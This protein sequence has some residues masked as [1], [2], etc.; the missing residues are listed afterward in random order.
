M[1]RSRVGAQV[2][3]KVGDGEQ[4][5]SET[6]MG[7]L[8]SQFEVMLDIGDFFSSS[9]DVHA[10]IETAPDPA[11]L[12]PVRGLIRSRIGDYA[13]A[14]ADFSNVEDDASLSQPL[15][16][17]L[18][19]AMVATGSH[20]R[21]LEV[22][23]R[24]LSDEFTS[25]E[26][27][28]AASIAAENSGD[29]ATAASY[30]KQAF[31]SDRDDLS[32][33]L[34]ALKLLS[35]TGDEDEIEDWRREVIG[36][37]GGS[38][39]GAFEI[40]VWAIEN[41]DEAMFAAGLRSVAARDKGGTVDLVED[42]LAAGMFD[43]VGQSVPLLV[44]IGR[45]P[46]SLAERRSAL[47]ERLLDEARQMVVDGSNDLAFRIARALVELDGA[48]NSQIAGRRL[49]GQA[50]RVLR[51][52]LV[53]VRS[54]VREAYRDHDFAGVCKIYDS[55]ADIIT[56]DPDVATIVARSLQA[57]ERE[58]EA[59]ALILRVQARSPESFAPTRW[60]ARLAALARNY[61]V[62]LRMYGLLRSD[63]PEQSQPIA[64]EVERF[65]A[66]AERVAV[67]QLRELIA[68]ERFEDASELAN[69]ILLE[70]NQADRVERELGR[71][72]RA[73]R[74]KLRG[75]DEGDGEIDEREAVLRQ[76]VTL[77]PEDETLLRRLALELMRQF[78]FL[79]AAE[80]W[81]RIVRIN[82]ENESAERNLERC[83]RLAAS[84][85]PAVPAEAD[86]SG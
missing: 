46:R 34:H 24:L 33:A 58:A 9:R 27:Y 68:E 55:Q 74:I 52:V 42:A 35:R 76:L 11:A 73:L 78:R 21:A 65:F 51:D 81:D 44:T 31:R 30:A 29:G 3:A 7:A 23:E 50:R 47:L 53:D 56:E 28:R 12:L 17:A 60:A 6:Q 75:I 4:P 10:A 37:A 20:E 80:I 38:S 54:S 57:A 14:V 18:L 48:S 59:L 66:I 36:N 13:G 45:V 32:A 79:E 77:K 86:G 16:L 62:A 40:C 19:K 22:A 15:R 61:T 64:S 71:M 1:H 2:L 49:A 63:F 8:A 67:R 70:L 5:D 43:A 25:A 85:A 69:I 84:R 26:I 41:R 72:V 82:P 83:R 39:S